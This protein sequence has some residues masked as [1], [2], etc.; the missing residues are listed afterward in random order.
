MADSSTAKPGLLDRYGRPI[1]REALTKTVSGPTLTGVRSPMTGYP[2]DGL[3]PQRLASILRAA[4]QG[5]LVQYLELAETIEERDP[6]YLAVISTRKRAVAQ[7][8][9]T[10][11]AASDDAIHVSHADMV[12]DWLKREEL[13]DEIFNILDSIGKGY[14]FTEIIWETSTGHW[15]P[16][17]LEWRDPRWFRFERHDLTTPL[18]LDEYGQ[19]KPLD[20]FKFIV[21]TM[22]A[23]SGLPLRGGLARLAS[24][25]WMFKAYTNRDWQIFNQTYGQ[26]VRVGKYGAGA[27]EDDKATLFRAVANIAGDCAA[28]IPESMLIEFIESSNVGSSGDLYEHRADWLD[29]QISKAVLGQ[30]A[31]TDAVI[32]G[33]GSGKEHQLV[34][35]DIERADARALSAVL[36]RDL[37]RP[38]IDLE[39]GPQDKYPRLIIARPEREDMSAL[40]TQLGILVPLG[41]KVSQREVRDKMGLAEPAAGDDILASAPPV[42]PAG[43]PGAEPLPPNSKIKRNPGEIKRG[44]PQFGTTPALQASDAVAPGNRGVAAEDPATLLADRLEIEAAPAM[45]AMI[46]QIEAMMQAAT[47]LDEFRAMLLA[48]FPKIDST[49]LASALA[50]GMIAADAAGRV[51]VETEGG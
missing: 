7:I 38:W 5:D 51:A 30:T 50:I 24:W 41:F 28:I 19:E 32:G 20:P 11:E 23:K 4:D 29:K 42:A 31:T 45:A 13:Q 35:E 47:S 9:I 39:Y 21:T 48:G 1:L 16:K 33:L 10:V 22:Q 2:A 15:W 17:R 14:S 36:N 49:A 44:P 25:G 12:R 8:D 26:P 46:G 34:R 18:K 27:S 6:H 43:P 37:V 3:T 40:A